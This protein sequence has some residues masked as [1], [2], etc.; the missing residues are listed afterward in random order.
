MDYNLMEALDLLEREKGVPVETI[1]DALANALVSAY[2][3]TPGAAE[4]ARVTIDA[5][6]GE[7]T[8]FGQELDED[9]N[10]VREWEDTPDDFGRIAAQ[11]AKQVIMQR[12]RDA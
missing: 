2:K 12:L 8:V 9:G 4:E 10:V 1:L 5:D 6:T 3:R 7:I 11:T